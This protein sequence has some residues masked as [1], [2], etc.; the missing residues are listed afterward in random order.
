[1]TV[2]A[3]SPKSDSLALVADA[4]LFT[5]AAF[6]LLVIIGGLLALFLGPATAWR[7]HGR[8]IDRV[9]AI[10]GLIGILI[11]VLVVG[12]LFALAPL[13][14]AAIGPVGGWE[15]A[16]PA[17]FLGAAGLAFLALVVGL[18]M[19]SVRDLLPAHREHT[20]LDYARLASTLVI[21]VFV[22]V[23]SLIQANRPETEVGDA[24]VFALGAAAA[25]A[26]TMLAMKSVHAYWGRRTE[27]AGQ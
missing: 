3:L 22:V 26:V 1:V 15:F 23:V 8:R 25:G 19:D 14:S 24:G 21:V 4:S 10:S 17:A 18:D 11:S 6:C 13:A 16:A 27:S 20:H 12:S 7:L 5:A 9:A 2:A